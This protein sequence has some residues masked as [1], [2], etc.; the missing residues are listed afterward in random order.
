MN[1]NPLRECANSLQQTLHT[2]SE[3]LEAARERIEGA[4]RLHHLI[5]LQLKEDDVLQEM[6]LLAEKIGK[7]DLLDRFNQNVSAMGNASSRAAAAL[8]ID[9]KRLFNTSTP[10]RPNSQPKLQVRA[11][12]SKSI[13]C[14]SPDSYISW[15]APVAVTGHVEE[16]HEMVSLGKANSSS[17]KP[18]TPEAESPHSSLVQGTNQRQ[19]ETS[20]FGMRSTVQEEDE[21]D[22]SKIADS[23]LGG[24]DRCEGQDAAKMKRACSC[25]SFED[26]TMMTKGNDSDDMDEDEDE[27]FGRNAKAVDHGIMSFQPNSHLFSHSSSLNMDLEAEVPG[28]DQKTQK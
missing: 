9:V 16:T 25:Q 19:H 17:S 2:F 10:E 24:C 7:P 26:A 3:R 1:L 8:K 6:Q 18:S 22:H 15:L 5:G 4:T 28:I 11:A 14:P 23:G 13:E 20:G 27:C 21:E 12:S